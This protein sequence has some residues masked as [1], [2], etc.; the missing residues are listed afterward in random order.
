VRQLGNVLERAVILHPGGRLAAADLR[1]AMTG[2]EGG[3]RAEVESALE[4]AAGDKRRAAELLGVSYR[5]LQ[6]KVRHY[7]LEG[8]PRYRR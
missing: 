7:D 4:R 2:A 6:R 8:F 5:T 3:G 1:Q